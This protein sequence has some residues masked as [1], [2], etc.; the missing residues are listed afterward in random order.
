[1]SFL[2]GL[3]GGKPK[4]SPKEQVREWSS[5]LKKEQRSLQREMTKIERE[6]AKT[7]IEIKKLAKQG[8]VAAVKTMAKSLIKSQNT[9]SRVEPENTRSY[10]ERC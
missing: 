6:E 9:R 8:H 10:R 2:D 5:G 1:M 3:F 4:L 7:K